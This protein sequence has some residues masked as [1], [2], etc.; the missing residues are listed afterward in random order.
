MQ[1]RRTPAL[2]A[3][4]ASLL[5][6]VPAS[7]SP[8]AMLE[9]TRT[10]NDE[11]RMAVSAGTTT[12]VSYPGRVDVRI[13]G[14]DSFSDDFLGG[15]FRFGFD[16]SFANVFWMPGGCPALNEDWGRDE[17]YAVMDIYNGQNRF[18]EELRSPT[19]T[20]SY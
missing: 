20:G 2:L 19:V 15:P 6:A 16:Q 12:P 8:Y 13:Y 9:I 17:I 3:T 10:P 4:A 1:I 14:E 11:C 7:A 5:A 18:V